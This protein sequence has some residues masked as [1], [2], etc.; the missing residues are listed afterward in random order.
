MIGT[1]ELCLKRSSSR[2]ESFQSRHR[3]NVCGENGTTVAQPGQA[4]PP[5]HLFVRCSVH[6]ISK[7][8]CRCCASRMSPCFTRDIGCTMCTGTA[9]QAVHMQI[10]I[11]QLTAE[12]LPALHDNRDEQRAHLFSFLATKIRSTQTV[13]P[14]GAVA[15]PL[16]HRVGRLCQAEDT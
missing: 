16:R 8:S 11:C 2:K 10:A 1:F 14:F 3:A 5:R 6:L 12:L 15:V 4:R 9:C 13:S 7:W